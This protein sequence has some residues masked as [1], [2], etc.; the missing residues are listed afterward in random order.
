MLIVFPVYTQSNIA[1]NPS[2]YY[3]GI[4]KSREIKQFFSKIY[5]NIMTLDS[6]YF[7]FQHKIRL[8]HVKSLCLMLRYSIGPF[9]KETLDFR[10]SKHCPF[11]HSH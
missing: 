3:W 1:E 8:R 5:Y 11:D 6:L 10:F 9:G 2:I 4:K 7:L